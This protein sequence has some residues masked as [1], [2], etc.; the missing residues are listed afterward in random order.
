MVSGNIPSV[1]SRPDCWKCQYFAVSWDP[2][3][4]YLC[5]L[6]GFKSRNLPALEVIRA[7]G[8]PCE[9]FVPKPTVAAKPAVQVSDLRR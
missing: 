3:L 9:G 5:K 4:P 6:F 7:D 1:P 2:K 8:K